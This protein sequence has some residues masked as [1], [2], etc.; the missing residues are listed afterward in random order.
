MFL[1]GYGKIQ[2]RNKVSEQ[3]KAIKRNQ[4]N[5]NGQVLNGFYGNIQ[6]ILNV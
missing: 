2:I 4:R 5:E 6:M 3:K 1:I